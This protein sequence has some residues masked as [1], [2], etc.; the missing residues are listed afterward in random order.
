MNDDQMVLSA[1]AEDF[2]GYLLV[3]LDRSE[4]TIEAYSRDL[5]LFEAYLSRLNIKLETV[6]SNDIRAFIASLTQE[7]SPRSA[8]RIVSTVRGFFRYLVVV[9]LRQE[10]P[11]R[12]IRIHAPNEVLP[13]ALPVATVLA[14]IDSVD[15]ATPIGARDRV[16]LEILYGSGL[17]VTELVTVL[18]GAIDCATGWMTVDGKGRRQRRV[19]IS[20]AACHMIERYRRDGRPKLV[21]SSRAGRVDT[22]IVNARGGVLT[23]QGAWFILKRRA[24]VVGV[25]SH[26]SPHVLR[27]SCATHMVE[28]GAD[29]R[30][31]Q[32]ILGHSSISTTEIYTKVSIAHLVEVYGSTHPR[33]LRQS[34][35][36]VSAERL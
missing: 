15:P 18:D 25:G 31:V 19:P 3:V 17:R 36:Q 7:R 9:G 22:L 10:D 13:K 35:S 23:R 4:A 32:E 6:S 16:M 2:L 8:A 21:R 1:I 11:M 12:G 34:P 33:A 27:H 26:F 29:L 5:G 30:V 20:A 14:L 24:E 28:S